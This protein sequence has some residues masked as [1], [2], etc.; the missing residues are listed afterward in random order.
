MHKQE[1]LERKKDEAF[2]S[3][4]LPDSQLISGYR[5][6]LTHDCERHKSDGYLRQIEAYIH[7]SSRPVIE[8]KQ[9]IKVFAPF[10]RSI[11]AFRTVTFGQLLVIGVLAVATLTG[12]FF[13][14]QLFLM[15]LTEASCLIYICHF[16]T[17][18][19]FSTRACL[20]SPE[21][22]IDD[23]IIDALFDAE[24]PAYTVLRPLYHEAE[25]VPQFVQAM[26]QLDY[27]RTRL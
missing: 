7:N 20:S 26:Q 21:E 6:W 9:E 14:H 10:Q 11:S 15:L 25:V 12:L 2:S 8:H 4:N 22:K 3:A 17:I 27:P 18:A 19:F 1:L 5:Q 24:W 13:Q 23:A 16:F